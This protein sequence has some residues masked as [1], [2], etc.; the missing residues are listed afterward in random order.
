MHFNYPSEFIRYRYF[1]GLLRE[2]TALALLAY[3]V[4]QNGQKFSEFG[5]A[6]RASDLLYGMLLWGGAR[7]CYGLAYPGILYTCELLGWQ[8]AP[9]YLP[10]L[11]LGL[12]LLTYCF[13]VVNPVYEEMLVRGFL[14]SE[15]IGLTGSS[16]LAVLFSVLLQ[17]SYH[18]YQGVPYAL[19]ASVIFLIYSVYYARTQRIMPLIVAHFMWDLTAH[20][21]HALMQSRLD[22]RSSD[23]VADV[24]LLPCLPASD[25]LVFRR[26]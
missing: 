14:M 9:P 2:L 3:V 7:L 18:L 11:S 21:S 6:F 15:T 5:V 12:G 8:P 16:T 25:D 19:A 23:K 1:D 4:V 24:N 20:L 13:V 22:T 17:T 10:S 26:S